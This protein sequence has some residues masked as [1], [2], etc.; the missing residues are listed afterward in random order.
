M[1]LITD[2]QTFYPLSATVDDAWS[3]DNGT[4]SGGTFGVYTGVASL[5]DQ[6]PATP[7]YYKASI[8]TVSAQVISPFLCGFGQML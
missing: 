2:L 3:G 5:L 7:M 4:N 6:P 8:M 1:P